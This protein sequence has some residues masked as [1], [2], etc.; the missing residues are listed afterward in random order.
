MA[1]QKASLVL[2]VDDEDAVCFEWLSQNFRVGL[3]IPPD[4]DSSSWYAIGGRNKKV[5]VAEYG[6]VLDGIDQDQALI[7]T[8]K[9]ALH[10]LREALYP[11]ASS[12]T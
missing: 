4:I 1:K 10:E 3:T 9:R 2:I 11:I 8:C 6:F 12:D 5:E 7:D